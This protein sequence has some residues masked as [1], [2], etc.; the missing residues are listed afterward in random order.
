MDK[1]KL[2]LASIVLLGFNSIIG[3]GIFLLPSR[4]YHLAGDWS[5]LLVLITAGIVAT[6]A[7]SFAEVS[8]YFSKNGAAYV[9]T[10][11]A[12]GQFA[13]FE[14]GFLKWIMQCI[15]W[16]VMAVALTNILANT[17]HFEDN[18][19]LR[20]MIIF[21]IVTS[22]T[23]L[24]LQGVNATKIVNNVSTL[25]KMLPLVILIAG[26]IWSINPEFIFPAGDAAG[27]AE[28]TLSGETL[29][30]ALILC[31]YAYTG[32]ETFGTAAEDMENPKRNLPLAIVYV[33]VAVMVFY[34]LVM[35]VCVGVL[36]PDIANSKVPVADTARAV[37]GDWGF[38]M[39]TIGSII[40]LAGINV[41]A[42]F[43][44]PR[45]LLPLSEDKMVPEFFGKKNANGV[46]TVAII[47]S[48]LVTIPIALSGSFTTLAMLS[49][50]T[51]FAQYIPT[52]L[53]VLVFRKRYANNPD[54]QPTFKV[55]FGPTLPALGVTIC[56]FLLADQNPTKIMVGLGAMVVIA[57]LYF[58]AQKKAKQSAA[59]ADA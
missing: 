40:S 33:I 41:A 38:Y 26:G 39:I 23:F 17:F 9:Y 55:P 27:T 22:L 4:L 47:A 19:M 43:H 57:P 29:G 35:A 53:A 1:K 46:P 11:E 3:S 14:V 44:I 34:A 59:L 2:G 42:S 6:I 10:K 56:L 16:G 25:A 32:F 21:G 8:G 37:F 31:F 58:M 52:C 54:M 13:G 30:S 12:F 5:V 49:V 51:R 36:G 15:A 50:V 45:A 20:N 48:A 7:F 24:N 18:T 28:Y